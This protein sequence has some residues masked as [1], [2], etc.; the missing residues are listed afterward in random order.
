MLHKILK[1]IKLENMLP[2]NKQ[3]VKSLRFDDTLHIRSKFKSYVQ[4]N[5]TDL[6]SCYKILQ[7]KNVKLTLLSVMIADE[8]ILTLKETKRNKVRKCSPQHSAH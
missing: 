4:K 3:F 7:V 2:K 1:V 6:D 8:K 5:K